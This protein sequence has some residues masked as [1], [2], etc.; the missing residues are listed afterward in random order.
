MIFQ[1]QIGRAKTFEWCPA[2]LPDPTSTVRVTFY[3]NDDSVTK[4]LEA[5]SSRA[6]T[7]VPDSY[8][9]SLG[10][11]GSSAFAGLVGSTGAGGWYLHLDGFGQFPVNISHFDDTQNELVL[12]EPLP[13]AVPADAS[14]TI[15]HNKWRC[16]LTANELGAAI[17]RAGYYQINYQVDDDPGSTN[18]NVRLLS[19]R[20]RLRVVRAV[21]HTGLTAS[22]LITL[23]PQL[24]ATRPASREGWQPYINEFDI[25]GEV[26]AKLPNNRYADQTLGEQFRR[27]HALFVAA[28]L[29][30]IGYAPNVDPERMRAAAEAELSR[31][32]QRLHWID[33][34][35]DG[36][37]DSDETGTNPESLVS[38]TRS[39][40]TD[41]EQD[42]TQ[43][44]RYR[45]RLDDFDDR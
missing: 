20:G 35:D 32:V 11:L 15:Y 33:S 38:I 24:E 1:V 18:V 2:Y 43:G 39:S 21:F 27:A 3:A 17:D 41:T 9:L 25:L 5:A 8:R 12:A 30:E 28:S 16:V 13:V 40:N 44:R 4:N 29:A 37:I 45:P 36:V 22:D 34:D 23:V 31:Q 26:E 7:G 6:V 10:E 14:G 19:E 42:Y